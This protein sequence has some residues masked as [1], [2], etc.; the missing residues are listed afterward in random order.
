MDGTYET[1]QK[2]VLRPEKA[3]T[4]NTRLYMCFTGV[5]IMKCRDRKGRGMNEK[6][7]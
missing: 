3:A 1:Y 6:I 5:Q 4:L 2:S 7:R